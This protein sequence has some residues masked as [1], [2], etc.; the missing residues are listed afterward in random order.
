ML[1]VLCFISFLVYASFIFF[2]KTPILL[3][4]ILIINILLMILLKI[5]IKKAIVFCLKLMP[6]IL[7]T[8]I[9]NLIYGGIELSVLIALRLI[10][11]CNITYI[12]SQKQTP[13]SLGYTIE[14]VLTPLKVFKVNTKEIRNNDKY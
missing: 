11:V 6:F 3:G 2:I 5:N 1:K 8:A 10:L 13:R 14:K 7:F 12:F 9:F 4:V